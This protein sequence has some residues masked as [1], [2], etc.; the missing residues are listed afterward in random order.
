MHPISMKGYTF[1]LFVILHNCVSLTLQANFTAENI[2]FPDYILDDKMLDEEYKD[3]S[4][5]L[6]FGAA[7]L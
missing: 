5:L 1:P 4:Y 2:G 7:K 6:T 3:V